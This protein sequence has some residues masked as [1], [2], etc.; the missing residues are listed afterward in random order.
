MTDMLLQIIWL[1][2]IDALFLSI[3]ALMLFPMAIYKRAAFAVLRRNFISYFSNPTGYVFLCLFVLLT[4]FSA[5]WP[6]EFFT[7]NLANLDQLNRFL[8]FIML[9]FV[10]AITMGVWA[11][12][13]RQGTDELLLTIPAD[14]FDIVIGK[15]LAAVGVFTASL[16][17]SQI[18]NY[19]VLV[20][21]TNAS[22]DTGLFFAN[23]FGYWMIGL[24]MIAI[25]M[26]GSFISSNLTVSFILGALFNAPLA[27]STFADVILPP[28]YSDWISQWSISTQFEPFGRGVMNLGSIAFFLMITVAGLYVCIVLISR[29]HWLGG[30]DGDSLLYHYAV[31]ILAMGA[32]AIA[33]TAIFAFRLSLRPDLTKNRTASLSVATEQILDGLESEHPIVVHA[34]ISRGVPKEYAE[35]KRNLLSLLREFEAGGKIQVKIY[36]NIET[37]SDEAALAEERF[38]IEPQEVRYRS[39]GQ[40]VQDEIILGAAFTSGLHRV[41]VPFF[42]YGVPVEYEMIRSIATVAKKQRKKLGV[43]Q[44]DAQMM[45][46]VS[47]A[48]GRPQQLPKQAIIIELEKQYD[49][50]EVD[51]TRPIDASKYDALLA[52]QPSSLPPEGMT[53]LIAAIVGGAPTAV[54]EDPLPY[55]FSQTPGTGQPKQAPGGM[56]G[57]GGAPMPKAD[58]RQLWKLLGITS[59]GRVN[60]QSF[61]PPPLWQPD[62]VWQQF[63]PYQKIQIN[64]FTDEWVF[65]RNEAPGGENSLT[66]DEDVTTGIDEVLLPYPAAIEPAVDSDLRFIKL[67][68]TGSV[69]GTIRHDDLMRYEGSDPQML[70]AK[71]IQRG[72]QVLAAWIRGGKKT[73]ATSTDKEKHINVIYVADVDVFAPVF[74]NLRARP[75]EMSEI[76]WQFENITFVLNVMDELSGDNAFVAVRNHKSKHSTLRLVELQ[77]QS[78]REHEFG[79][80]VEF[81]NEFQKAVKN[82]E[83]E[84]DNAVSSIDKRLNDMRTKQEKGENVNIV[85]ML[86]LSQQYESSVARAERKLNIRKIGLSKDRDR[87]IKRIRRDIDLQIQQIQFFYKLWAVALPPILPALIG[88]AV[89]FRRLLREREGI[90]RVRLK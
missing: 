10:P 29:R 45:G 44:T 89:F 51:A 66:P 90:E 87:Q 72:R 60:P 22:M 50:E 2:T 37:F 58:I 32:I 27:F 36:N 81:Q 64:A 14:D 76:R 62:V 4:S 80:R 28:P 88:I 57:G 18:S 82:A 42:D 79:Q 31:R 38:G 77:V 71:Q 21:L 46:G 61:R 75:D 83:Q 15:Y 13:K 19:V 73:N 85:D 86:A 56:M 68:Q 17:F 49:V 41:V 20:S 65:V 54:F 47:F 39:R 24:S 33:V 3:L 25:G 1:L 16:L 52:V 23:Y 69:S 63:N 12:E 48:G 55:F 5:F 9:I 35:V 53:N 7:S 26:T 70:R 30:R 40:L 67:L 11:E 8:P 43:I 6:H 34:F 84:K 74:L 78:A 59:P